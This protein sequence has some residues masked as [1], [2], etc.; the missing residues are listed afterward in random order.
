MDQILS[1]RHYR[2]DLIAHSHEHAQVVISLS[3]QLDFEVE[4]RPS[5]LRQQQLMVVPAGAHHTCGSPQGSHCLVL[6]VPGDNWLGQSLGAHADASRRLLD[7][8]GHLPLDPQQHQLVNWLAT[9]PVSDPLIA[10]QGAILLLASLNSLTLSRSNPAACP[11][12]PSMPISS[13]TPPTRC[14][15]RI[16]RRLPACPA[17]AC[18]AGLSANVGKR[19]WTTSANGA[20]A[21]P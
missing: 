5:L 14:R 17:P 21:V 10:R 1:L 13:R 2:H 20:F 12:P 15:S 9:S 19:R 7:T 16:W 11:T 4:G 3:G 18:T 6:D 8:A